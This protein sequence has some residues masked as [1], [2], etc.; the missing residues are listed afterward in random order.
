[1]KW[2]AHPIPSLAAFTAVASGSATGASSGSTTG[3]KPAPCSGCS[4][5]GGSS[6]LARKCF[7]RGR[8]SCLRKYTR[9]END[10]QIN[11]PELKS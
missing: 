8:H 5:G 2:Q 4:S 9:R 10:Y 6:C 7:L 11:S 3:A 1:M